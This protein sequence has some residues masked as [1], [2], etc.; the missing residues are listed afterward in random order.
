MGGSSTH[1]EVRYI[2]TESEESKRIRERNA[3]E[4]KNREAASKE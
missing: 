2:Q 3:L 4:E 1:Y